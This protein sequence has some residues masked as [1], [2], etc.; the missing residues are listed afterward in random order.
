MRS[1]SSHFALL[2]LIAGFFVARIPLIPRRRFDPD[3]FEHAHDAWLMWKG[4]VPYKDFFEHHTPWYYYVLRPFYHWI[5]VA[6][7]FEN[8]H[9]FLMAARGLSLVLMAVATYLVYR[10]GRAWRD[11]RT[12]LV[13]ALF[14]VAQPVVLQKTIEMRPDMLALPFLLAGL[15]LLLRELERA[16]DSGAPD[17]R[18]FIAA[19]FAVGA[20]IMCTQKMMF[21]LPG[22]LAGLGIWVLRGG[23]AGI[24]RRS[25]AI[26][27]FVAGIAIPA[28]LTWVAF[29]A[30]HAGHEFIFNNFVVNAQ[31][32]HFETH[33]WDE[34]YDTSK[35]LLFVALAGPLLSLFAILRMRERRD[36]DVLLLCTGLGVFAGLRII[37]VAQRQYYL[38]LFPIV[39]LWAAQA[40]LWGVETLPGRLGRLR[41]VLFGLALFGLLWK[42]VRGVN[43]EAH[44]RNSEQLA[45][46]RTV[47]ERTQPTD[48][49]MDGWEGMGVFRP[50]AF[51][52]FFLHE[53]VR[54][55]L[56]SK[57]V[58][59]LLVELE[60]GHVRPKLIAMD[61]NLRALGPRFVSFVETHY[62]SSDGFLYFTNGQAGPS[63]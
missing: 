4:M 2:F 8:A 34:V 45:K 20:A 28:A 41:S 49:V 25:S 21:A 32:K 40:L 11:V 43:D 15:L 46:L 31:W 14:F 39:C 36:G 63:R 51:Y 24:L 13:A 52:Y 55:V 48:I 5:A 30:R 6:A 26:L 58:D 1:R 37:P 47:F 35:P 53:E 57:P 23:R 44:R 27:V 17:L 18:Q 50:H 56:P 19:G 29:A 60:S 7:S 12:G 59:A 42:P 9:R 22:L 33:M 61:Q 16:P 54:A 3:E 10:I 38:M 62:T